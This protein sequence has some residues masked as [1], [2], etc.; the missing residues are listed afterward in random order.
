MRRSLFKSP[1]GGGRGQR[2]RFTKRTAATAVAGGIASLATVG[3]IVASAAVPTPDQGNLVVFPDRDFITVE[4]FQEY[5]GQT[6]RIEVT[7]GTQLKGAAQSPVAAGEVAF[8]VNHP[9][10]VCWGNY[11]DAPNV[12]P[13]ILPG[14]KVTIKVGGQSIADTTVQDAYVN[15]DSVLDGN[16]LTVK[17]KI[18]SGVQAAQT[19]Q[20]IVNPDL[21]NT[22]IGRRD[23]RAL[24]GG[25]VPSDKGGYSSGLSIPGDGTFTATYVFDT[26]EAAQIAASG[27]GERFMAWQ[28]ESVDA[29]GEAARQ[30]LTIAEYKE[31]GGP[32]MGGCPAGPADAGASKPGTAT[33]TRN[34]AKDQI[35]VKW[36]PAEPAPGAEATSGYSVVAIAKT[37]ANNEFVQIGKRVGANATSATITSLNTTTDYSVEVRSLAG[38]RMS[39]AYEVVTP[40]Q[41]QV[42]SDTTVPPLTFGPVGGT[43]QAEA[44]VASEVRLSSTDG[45]GQIYYTTDGSDALNGDMPSDSS[46][47]Y[48]G[49][50]PITGDTPVQVK[51]VVFDDAG[52]FVAKD[53]WYSAAAPPAPEP[54]PNAPTDLTATPSETSVSLRWT[55]D[56]TVAGYGVQV[57]TDAAGTQPLGGLRETGASTLNVTGLTAATDYWFTLKAKSASGAW[58]PESAKVS[59]KTLAVPTERVTITTARYRANDEFRIT[60]TGTKIGTQVTVYGGAVG[61]TTRTIGSANIAAAGT[62]E[63]RL[64]NGNTGTNPGTVWVRTTDG[65]TAGPFT[66]TNR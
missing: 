20:R 19:E 25:V 6:A 33:A 21:N 51:A 40:T 49:P 34:V 61:N 16:T 64:R 29:A 24:P 27:G 66:V 44:V 50:I 32:G 56:A 46:A 2:P 39:E 60:G 55:N 43:T 4:G 18:A 15:Q 3:A 53:G 38:A 59:V 30:G 8:E 48:T 52:N 65:A 28:E 63:V 45:Q 62:W 14:D 12:T 47:L 17:G 26:A 23:I 5:V 58:G 41:A 31:L 13:D 42:P 37:G 22:V 10:G 57:Y 9:G 1:V 35:A 7:R 36:T 11:T 54:G